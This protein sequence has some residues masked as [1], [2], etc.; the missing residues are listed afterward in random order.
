MLKLFKKIHTIA[1]IITKIVI[2]KKKLKIFTILNKFY[3][4]QITNPYEVIYMPI[5]INLYESH[6]LTI[7]RFF[8][9]FHVTLLLWQQ[10]STKIYLILLNNAHTSLKSKYASKPTLT[11]E[12]YTK[13]PRFYRKKWYYKNEKLLLLFITNIFCIYG[14]CLGV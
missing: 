6:W 1:K 10:K 4:L 7:C 9:F 13:W 8:I 3:V 2:T 12:T 14:S 5:W 11:E